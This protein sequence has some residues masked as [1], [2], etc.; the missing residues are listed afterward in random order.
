MGKHGEPVAEVGFDITKDLEMSVAEPQA[1]ICAKG[2]RLAA[3]SQ[4]ARLL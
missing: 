3:K 1:A 4:S 2:L